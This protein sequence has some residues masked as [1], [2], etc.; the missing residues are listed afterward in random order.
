MNLV[1]PKLD[2]LRTL[3]LPDSIIV[4]DMAPHSD[5]DSAY[6]THCADINLIKSSLPSII[7]KQKCKKDKELV[8]SE[9]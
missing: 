3:A 2:L 6:L 1:C 8:S 9:R 4:S 5:S 7:H